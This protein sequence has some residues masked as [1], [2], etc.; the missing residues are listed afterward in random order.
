MS[1]GIEGIGDKF[2][3]KLYEKTVNDAVQTIDRYEIG[4][5]VGL[6]D[7]QTDNVV[8]V[9]VAQGYIK[10]ISGNKIQLSQDGRKRAEV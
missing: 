2:L 5:E 9:L 1:S 8:N 7:V 4:K 3:L 6:I 10:K